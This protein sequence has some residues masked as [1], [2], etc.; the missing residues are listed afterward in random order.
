[1]HR[2]SWSAAVAAVGM[3]VSVAHATDI[4]VA[5]KKLIVV[6]KLT[7]AGKA[8][9]VYVSKD[10]GAGITKGLGTDVDQISVQFNVAY[11]DGSAAGVFTLPVGASNGTDGWLVNKDTV[12]K[13]VNK[14][15]PDGTTEAKVAVIKPGKLLK[16]VGKGLG[17]VPL[18][19]FAAGDPGL[20]DVQTAYCVTNGGEEF[21]HCSTFVACAYKSIA[22]GT[23]AKLVCKTGAGDGACQA[24]EPACGNDPITTCQ[25]GDGCCPAACGL[26]NDDDCTSCFVDQ[27]LTVLDTCTNLEWEKKDTAV[28]S[29]VDA[30]NLHDVDNSYSWAGRCTIHPLVLCQPNAAAAATC[31]AQTGGAFGCGECGVGDGTCDP[32]PLGGI[33]TI[34]DWVSQL[35]A[36]SFAGH[37]NWRLA[38]SAGT[39]AFPTGEFPELESIVDLNVFGFSPLI[40]PIFGPTV[41]DFYWSATTTPIEPAGAVLVDFGL[42]GEPLVGLVKELDLWIRAVRPAS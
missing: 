30:G 2:R 12:A 22:G 39:E 9:L 18:D 10:Q 33:T 16:I 6:D 21:C 7:A 26:G 25:N 29:G 28:G 17:D 3:M 34:W 23:G 1:M 35:N 41:M 27:G 19:I 37:N 5:P 11:G 20:S 32:V 4:P 36:A 15:A 40:N 42:V 14:D 8:K 24:S 38:T 31:A 13:Y